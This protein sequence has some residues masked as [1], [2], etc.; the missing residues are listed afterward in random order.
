MEF[1]ADIHIHSH[2]SRATSKKLDLEHLWIEAQRKGVTVV[3]TGDFTHPGW[4]AELSQKLA[5]AEDGLFRLDPRLSGPLADQV[6][7]ACRA[8]VRFLLSVEI[9]NIYKRDDATRKVHNV[10]CLPSLEQAARFNTALG[11]IG[12]IRSDGRPIL[13]LD[14]RDLLEMVLHSGPDAVLIPAHI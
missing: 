11:R 4:Y 9:S 8:P 10:V 6:P 5:P 2:F 14:S 3:G 13:G 1:V 12:N 7:A